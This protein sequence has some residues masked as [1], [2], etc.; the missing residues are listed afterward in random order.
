MTATALT[1][2][3]TISGLTADSRAVRPGW[4]FAA[5]PGTRADGRAFV[6]AAIAAGA[7]AILAPEGSRLD[8]P[9]EVVLVTDA[10]P[11]RRFALMASVFHGAQ[12]KVM[13]AVTGTNGKT[14]TA[15]FFRQIMARLGHVSASI[16]TLGVTAPGWDG[17]G[18]L[19]TP[20]PAG[21]HA[22]LAKLAGMGV[23]HACMEASSHGLDQHRL[24][25]VTFKAAAFTNL[26]RD[27]L[28]YH[29][30]METYAEAKLR[31]FAE[32]LPEDATAVINA[33][34][35]LAPR[36][37]ELCAKRGIAVLGYGRAATDL[38]LIAARPTPAGQ[39]LDLEIMGR[40][41][42]VHLPLAGRFQ[43]D[44]ALAALGLALA[45]GADPVNA[46]IAL[47]HLD[48]VP[49]RLQKVAARA[50]GA[51]VYVDYAHTPDALETVLKALRPHAARR[52]VAVFGCGGDRDPGKRP[53]MGAIGCRL[54][55]AMIVTD[56]NPRSEDPALIRAAVRGVCPAGIEIAD[57]RDAIRTA[58]AG[59][60]KG[61]VLVIAGKGHEQGQIVGAAVLP[62]D[63]AGEAREAVR[64][65]DGGAS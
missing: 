17:A 12:P 40:A 52:L 7:V 49:G 29:A 48:G 62:F 26:T 24:D 39:D 25:G 41:V 37:V 22:D 3:V 9:P 53:L 32:V 14:S 2:D 65:A 63:D 16:G 27:H 43:A 4:L 19:T 1:R 59:L 44:N 55:D 6:P 18:G 34:S 21:L 11:R 35:D 42:T 30:D 57:R 51:P 46:L 20:D 58:V 56:D 15:E 31:L 61:D 38:R 60:Q 5:L 23:T 45:C 54:A 47:G 64:L 10:N 28:D 8:L 33:D 50:N 13:A 36:L